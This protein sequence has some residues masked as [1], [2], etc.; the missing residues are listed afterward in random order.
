MTKAAINTWDLA[1]ESEATIFTIEAFNNSS[2]VFSVVDTGTTGLGYVVESAKGVYPVGYNGA[3]SG[4][5]ASVVV[6]SDY[7]FTASPDGV[8]WTWSAHGVSGLQ[9]DSLSISTEVSDTSLFGVTHTTMCGDNG[10]KNEPIS[11]TILDIEVT[12][13]FIRGDANGDGVIELGDVV[14]IINYVY[15]GGDPPIPMEAGDCTCDGIV[16]LGDIVYLINY[17]YRGG[18]PPGCP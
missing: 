6:S 18:P 8:Q 3:S 12:P 15:R 9:I 13:S 16:E 4:K 17:L 11:F 2:S 1:V 10:A 7:D 5:P 14:Y